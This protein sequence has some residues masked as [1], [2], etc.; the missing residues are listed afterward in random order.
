M[1]L[2]THKGTLPNFLLH[3]CSKCTQIWIHEHIRVLCTSY[4]TQY[5]TFLDHILCWPTAVWMQIFF[6]TIYLQR[7][8]YTI[9][10]CVFSVTTGTENII[11][12]KNK[13]HFLNT[14]SETKI[15]RLFAL[16][17]N[18][19]SCCIARCLLYTSRCV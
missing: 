6:T 16:L 15:T 13:P 5:Y 11:Y 1:I 12:M 17:R 4:R 7:L 14:R 10:A 8:N 9:K 19:L 18:Y 3:N 2:D